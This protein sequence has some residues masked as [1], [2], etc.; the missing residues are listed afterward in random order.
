MHFHYELSTMP[1]LL[2][3][4]DHSTGEPLT[5]TPGATN[6]YPV[7]FFAE[8]ERSEFNQGNKLNE[9]HDPIKVLL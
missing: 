3:S 1:A 7:K 6:L 5:C 2:N 9:L 4:V 8:D